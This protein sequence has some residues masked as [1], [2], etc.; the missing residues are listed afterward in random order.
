M[1][2]VAAAANRGDGRRRP[3][4]GEAGGIG[5]DAVKGGPVTKHAMVV[6]RGGRGRG[7]GG[8]GEEQEEWAL[9]SSGGR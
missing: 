9:R 7:G 8:Q 4:H 2:V 1:T 3:S 6:K 5:R